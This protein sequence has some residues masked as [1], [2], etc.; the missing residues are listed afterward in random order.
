MTLPST[1]YA[2]LYQATLED[3]ATGGAAIMADLVKAVR[4][5]LHERVQMSRDLRE[6]EFHENALRLLYAQ[7]Q[8]LRTQYPPALLAAFRA[9]EAVAKSPTR[10]MDEVQFD[11]LELMD[12]VQVQESVSM[13]R[14]QQMALLTAEVSLGELNTLISTTL[15]LPTVRPDR[16]PLRPDVFLQ[17]LKQVVERAP[18]PS[19]VRVDWISTMGV[20]LGA[21]LRE[22]Y[23]RLANS[24]RAQGVQAAGYAVTSAPGSAGLGRGGAPGGG[25]QGA[26]GSVEREALVAQ[27]LRERHVADPALL[28][29]DRLHKLLAGELEAQGGNPRLAAFSAQFAQNFETP[30]LR[31]LDT[32]GMDFAATMP[33]ALE[34]LTEMKQVDRVVQRLEQRRG[35]PVRMAQADAV[36]KA[37][38]AIRRR[39]SG[40]AKTLSLEVVSL[41]VDNIAHDPRLL[42]PVHALVRSLEPALMQ[43]ALVDPRFFIDK[44]HVARELL[45]DITHR[46]LA[47]TDE[48]SAGFLNFCE[49][50][51]DA[52]GPLSGENVQVQGPEPFAHA[53][54]QLRALWL[55]QVQMQEAARLQAVRALQHAEQRN[56]LAE[57]IARDID[58]HPDAGLVPPVVTAFLCG[59][60]AQVV[61]Q[62]RVQGGAAS[63]AADKYQAL[64]SA[65]LWSTHPVLARENVAKLTRL[66]PLLIATLREGLE[67]IHYPATKTSTFLESL[68]GLHQQVFS[69]A[70]AG[71]PPAV[72]PLEQVALPSRS[73]P[74]QD[75]DP[76]IAPEEARDSNL[77]EFPELNEAAE[78]P[79]DAPDP[80]APASVG[81]AGMPLG[82]WVEL[83]SQDQWVRMQLTWSSPHGTLFLFTGADGRTRSMTRRSHDKLLA[84]GHLR[85][86]SG[87][88]VVDGALD[89]V[90]QQAMR[91]S[92]DS[93]F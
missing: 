19:A 55:A 92:V 69:T 60:W 6:R 3:A 40:V 91:N 66:V 76:W 85:I 64:I 28:T 45:Q 34:A 57:K 75:G 24:L 77:M 35:A 90:A 79:R 61:A 63:K 58:A 41:M 36:Q 53:L 72:V 62:A 70:G 9:P 51:Q 2:A 80:L 33:A 52:L 44:Q 82:S 56:V 88:P 42:P 48:E 10:R 5:S 1:R 13:A 78:V 29:L 67:T 17:V 21:E 31:P 68:M 39:A 43:L 50:I 12:D 93:K 38:E 25:G 47:F 37:C 73:R 87:L 30:A 71:T 20:A 89:A 27:A 8:E 65:M 16:N 4:K 54:Q 81:V 86:I 26:P 59:P 74:V 46:S 14:A 11:Q 32:P 7:E 22:L 83:M 84:A 23:T 15:G 18:I 49:V